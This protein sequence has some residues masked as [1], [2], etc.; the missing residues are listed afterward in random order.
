MKYTSLYLAIVTLTLSLLSAC[1]PSQKTSA[2]WTP[3]LNDPSDWTIKMGGQDLHEDADKTFQLHDG[4]LKV[5]GEKR[6][7]SVKVGHMFY[8]KKPSPNFRLRFEYRFTGKQFQSDENW[9]EQ[10]GGVVF[11]A[12]SPTSMG[13]KQDYPIC[14]EFQLLGGK[15][16]GE[17][18]T[19]N[20]CTIGTQVFTA[21][22]LNPSHCIN[23]TSPT[24]DGDR[25]V[26]A[27]MEVWG[28]SL[29]RHY[30]EGVPVLEYTHPQIGGGFVSPS[31]DWIKG[32]VKDWEEWAANDGTPLKEGFLAI[33]A[34]DPIE[35]RAMELL[36]LGPN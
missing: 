17:R 4:I 18:P 15:N 19:G 12:Q 6:D 13:L 9:P 27:E 35:F 32:N 1:E 29:I 22:T 20:V 23:S 25:W 3:I 14:L 36:D 2:Q 28:D 5:Y 34:H 31:F 26:K 10:Y 21:D 8:N 11:H 7:Q 16:T 33:Q 30:I 24:F